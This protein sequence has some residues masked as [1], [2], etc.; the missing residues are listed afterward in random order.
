VTSEEQF[1]AQQT[2]VMPRAGSAAVV[3]GSAAVVAKYSYCA[4][5]PVGVHVL[6]LAGAVARTRAYLR[7]AATLVTAIRASMRHFRSVFVVLFAMATRRHLA[8]QR[9]GAVRCVP[10]RV[11]FQ[12]EPRMPSVRLAVEPSH[13]CFAEPRGETLVSA[14][15]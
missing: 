1:A 3:A 5:L 2:P 10:A 9:D 15:L 4:A 14:L 12:T 8:A 13:L 11:S 6:V 7:F